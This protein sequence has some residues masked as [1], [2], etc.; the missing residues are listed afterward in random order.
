MA[1]WRGRTDCRE[2]RGDKLRAFLAYGAEVRAA[3][4]AGYSVKDV[5]GM[6]FA[7]TAGWCCRIRCSAST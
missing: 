5:S 1:D 4:E 6:F 7:R 2:P 3:F